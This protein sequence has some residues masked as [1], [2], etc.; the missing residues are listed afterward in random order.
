MRDLRIAPVGD[1]QRT[2]RAELDI[3]GSERFV[4]CLNR[5]ADVA[6]AK[7]RAV[8]RKFSHDYMLQ[9]RRDAEQFAFVARIQRASLVFHEGVC[10]PRRFSVRHW[11]KITKRIRIGERPVLVE[12]LL[13]VGT[14]HVMKA[15]RVAAV[16]ARVNA[17]LSVDL[18]AKRIAA[19]LGEDFVSPLLGMIPP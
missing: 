3:D 19:P 12:A 2:V 13:Q 5:E 15:A 17:A 18:N 8:A 4:F 14:L 9:K 1:V 10:K 6:R 16:M 7:R 11:R